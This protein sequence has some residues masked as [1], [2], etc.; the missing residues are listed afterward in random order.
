VFNL[1]ENKIYRYYKKMPSLFKINKSI[2]EKMTNHPR[3]NQ[4]HTREEGVISYFLDP[5][6]YFV[7]TI[8]DASNCYYF[9][10]CNETENKKTFPVIKAVQIKDNIIFE[11]TAHKLRPHQYYEKGKLKTNCITCLSFIRDIKN[12]FDDRVECKACL[13]D[14]YASSIHY[15][16]LSRYSLRKKWI[17]PISCLD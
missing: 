16:I 10:T 2:A 12:E 7:E 4:S 9:I 15:K 11:K 17:K 1:G 8:A 3:V 6:I 13:K 14:P 5:R